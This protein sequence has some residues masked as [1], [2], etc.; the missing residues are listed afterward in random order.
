VD[1]E[2]GI[3]LARLD[4][5]VRES[6]LLILGTARGERLLRPTFGCGIHELVFG[7]T[8]TATV[9]RVGYEVREALLEWEPRID[10]LEVRVM[11]DR[12]EGNSLLIDVRYRVRSTN[13]VFNLVYPF[14]LEHRGG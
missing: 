5:S 9:A 2:G 7:G 6:I 3:A 10:V 12:V 13:N 1:E 14:Y 8:D 11:P 4:Q